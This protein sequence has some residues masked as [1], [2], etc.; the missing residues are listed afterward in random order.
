MP[1]RALDSLS[2]SFKPVVFELLAR[3]V[4]RGV[5]ILIVQSGR[6]MAEHN[7]NLASGASG[8]ALSK[9]LPRALRGIT[10][11]SDKVDAIDLCP[12]VLYDIAGPDKLAWDE[13]YRRQ[14][15]PEARAAVDAPWDI[16][17]EEAEKRAR[18]C[19]WHGGLDQ[20][21]SNS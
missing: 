1:D 8:I 17:G 11:E 10:V 9:H 15:S 12:Y 18:E 14:L 6:T 16:I 13:A 20:M 3:L 5:M 4:E 2:S 7:A 21:K 19:D